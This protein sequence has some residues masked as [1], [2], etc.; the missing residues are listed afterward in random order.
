MAMPHSNGAEPEPAAESGRKQGGAGS[1]ANIVA[2]F[3]RAGGYYARC[4]GAY[5]DGAG[6]ELPVARPTLSLAT[7]AL[8]DEIVLVGL[9]WRRPLSDARVYER[10]N[11]EVAD[12]LALYRKKGWLKKPAGFF[13]TPPTPTDVSIRS[14]TS[15]N[16]THE[17]LSFES[18]YQPYAGEPGRD[19]WLSYTGNHREYALMLR[20]PAAAVAGVRPRNRDGTR[21]TG[22]D[23]VPGLAS[24]RGSRAQRGAAGTA[25]ARAT[26]QGIAQG[27]GLSR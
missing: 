26:G 25:D 27:R 5:L 4:W 3:T 17:R 23:P 13:A 21:G 7:H 9:R 11:G 24:A 10:I 8:R 22:P 20:H 1:L 12:A 6:G 19:R 15:R 16:R 2:P 18:G 14:F